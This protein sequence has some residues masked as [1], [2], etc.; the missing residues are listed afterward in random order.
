[1]GIRTG[2]SQAGGSD[3]NQHMLQ[4]ESASAPIRDTMMPRRT[5]DASKRSTEESQ[6]KMAA[7]GV[8]IQNVQVAQ[9]ERQGHPRM[10]DYIK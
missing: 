2:W 6:P 10:A 1:M 9:R 4:H 8:Q 3:R 5:N 7:K